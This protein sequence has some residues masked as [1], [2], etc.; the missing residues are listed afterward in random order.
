LPELKGANSG[1]AQTIQKLR[2]GCTPEGA[3][4]NSKI[5]AKHSK[6]TKTWTRSAGEFLGKGG[7][8]VTV[9]MAGQTGKE[10]APGTLKPASDLR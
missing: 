8:N 4:P 10:D 7:D 3:F 2:E 6:K 1:V 9:F 5:N